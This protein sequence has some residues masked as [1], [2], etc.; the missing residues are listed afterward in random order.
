M[1]SVKPFWKISSVAERSPS[2]PRVP[3]SNPG[4]DLVKFW[5]KFAITPYSK[6]TFKCTVPI[7]RTF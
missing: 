2:K 3:G 7:K 4:W 1:F 5:V 6:E